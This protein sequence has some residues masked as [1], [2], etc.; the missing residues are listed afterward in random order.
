[1]TMT[2]LL[3]KLDKKTKNI[4]HQL[5]IHKFSEKE[6]IKIRKEHPEIKLVDDYYWLDEDG[7]KIIRVED[8]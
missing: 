2:T 5:P 8:K 6:L 7:G 3:F 4:K 1:M